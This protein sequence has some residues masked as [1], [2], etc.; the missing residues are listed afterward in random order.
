MN[1]KKRRSINK[2]AEDFGGNLEFCFPAAVRQEWKKYKLIVWVNKISFASKLS[3]LPI[4][5]SNS[6]LHNG[7]HLKLKKVILENLLFPTKYIKVYRNLEK[8]R[9]S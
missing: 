3:L 1:T 8:I 4:V 7:L 5:Q 2:A 6:C 9:Q